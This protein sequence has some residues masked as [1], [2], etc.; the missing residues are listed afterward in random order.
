[1]CFFD[2]PR[3]GHQPAG[4]FL[5][6]DAVLERL[7]DPKFA[8]TQDTNYYEL[9]AWAP[10]LDIAIADAD[11]PVPSANRSDTKKFNKDVDRLSRRVKSTWSSIDT[12]G[13][14]FAS[15]LVAKNNW[16]LLE[17]ALSYI[18]RTHPPTRVGI[19][20]SPVKK[21]EDNINQRKFLARFLRNGQPP[22][23]WE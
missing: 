8:V 19:L 12:G 20:N 13:S 14:G 9:A 17:K 2:D 6:I 18:V 3:A 15:R 21:R 7:D 5:S 23:P 4:E 22:A 16:Q 11:P 1:V 10:I